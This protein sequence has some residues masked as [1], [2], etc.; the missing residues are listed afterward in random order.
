MK[1]T[2]GVDIDN[3][4][5]HQRITVDQQGKDSSGLFLVILSNLFSRFV[6]NVVGSIRNFSQKAIDA[7]LML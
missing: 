6:N 5:D 7:S 1:M 2:E 3:H 4:T